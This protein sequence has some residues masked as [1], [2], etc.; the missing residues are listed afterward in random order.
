[1]EGHGLENDAHDGGG[2]RRWLYRRQPVFRYGVG[3]GG[4]R[5]TRTAWNARQKAVLR[6]QHEAGAEM[7]C[8]RC[9]RRL[10]LGLAG[11]NAVQFRASMRRYAVENN[12][13]LS[14]MTDLSGGLR[15]LSFIR[16]GAVLVGVGYAGFSL[17]PASKAPS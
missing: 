8:H 13:F 17:Q 12:V 5:S 2:S 6:D 10:E 9:H 11:A 4:D 16:L 3:D 14:D 7:L 15:A 1:V